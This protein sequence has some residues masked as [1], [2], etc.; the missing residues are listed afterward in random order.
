MEGAVWM[1]C[2]YV[3]HG[4]LSIYDNSFGAKQIQVCFGMALLGAGKNV[5]SRE[6]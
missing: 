3:G 4:C 5:V 6:I 1:G 2:V